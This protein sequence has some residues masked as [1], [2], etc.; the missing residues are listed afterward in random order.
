MH[1]REHDGRLDGLGD[2]VDGAQVQALLLVRD[3]VHGGHEDHRQVARGGIGTQA[4]EHGIAVH[5]RHHDVEQHEV[6]PGLARRD[7]QGADPGVGDPHAEMRRE[8][9]AQHREVL[10]RVVD[11]EDGAVDPFVALRQVKGQGRL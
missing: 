9:L 1:P 4:L 8:H 11:D 6:G 3:R 5:L 10:R 2:V 7:P